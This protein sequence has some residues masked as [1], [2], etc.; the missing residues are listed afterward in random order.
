MDQQAKIEIFLRVKGRLPNMKND[1]IDKAM[2][3]DFLDGCH[4]GKINKK[5][6]Y[7]MPL[8]FDIYGQPNRGDDLEP[9]N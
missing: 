1:R 9:E 3:K 6:H 5:Y 4:N 8:A 2:A 7:L